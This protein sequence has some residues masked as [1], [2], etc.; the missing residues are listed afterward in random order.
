MGMVVVISLPFILFTILIGFGC[1]FFG[2][3]KG[4]QDLRNNPQVFGVPTPPPGTC[5]TAPFPT[6]H[7]FKQ[8]NTSN[9]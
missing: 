5:V 6:T 8:D 9:V 4:R 2:R 1:F 7:D 3:A